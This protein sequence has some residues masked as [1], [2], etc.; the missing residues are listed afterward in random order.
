MLHNGG[1]KAKLCFIAI[2]RKNV[3]NEDEMLQVYLH[4]YGFIGLIVP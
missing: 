1:S 2:W 3:A 4:N